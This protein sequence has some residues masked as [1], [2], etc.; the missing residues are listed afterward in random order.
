[1]V[2]LA[3][4]FATDPALLLLDEPFRALDAPTRAT[5]LPVVR[6][7]L[8][9]TGTAAVLV[10]HDLD[11]AFAFGDR[12]AVMN[13][14]A[15]VAHGDAPGLVAHPPSREVAALLGV[16][17]IAAGVIRRV[18]NGYARVELRP[19]G[20]SVR[21]R[22][23][24]V[25]AVSPHQSVTLSLPARA[26]TVLPPG[27]DRRDDVNLLPGTVRAVTSLSTGVRLVVETPAPIVALASWDAS[28]RR[29][30]VGDRACVTFA[31]EAA[32][33]IPDGV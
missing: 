4:A 8:R 1:R 2:A 6:E 29:W 9:E 14:G 18:V 19:A 10:T 32:H 12:V 7:R 16:E 5:L 11:E 15:V 24:S 33:L 30:S 17:T 31:P 20:P 23:R 21:S 22:L 26:V 27:A 25:A 28:A 3:R 13:A